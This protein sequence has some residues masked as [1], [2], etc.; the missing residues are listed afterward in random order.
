MVNFD[1]LLLCGLV[2]MAHASEKIPR[3]S[4]SVRKP[5]QHY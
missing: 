2:K 1:I 5:L 3:S 4:V